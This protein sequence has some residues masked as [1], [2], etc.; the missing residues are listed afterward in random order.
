MSYCTNGLQ[1]WLSLYFRKVI[2]SFILQI[3]NSTITF[4]KLLLLYL[5]LAYTCL[6]VQTASRLGLVCTLGRLF[7]ALFYKLSLYLKS[8]LIEYNLKCQ[9]AYTC[10]IVQTASRL[11][12]VCTLGRLFPALFYKLSLYL[13]SYLIEYNLKCPSSIKIIYLRIV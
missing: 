10:L 11:G 6:I 13:K 7:P 5:E 2:S 3:L 4:L 9:L 12:L 8:Y 1:T